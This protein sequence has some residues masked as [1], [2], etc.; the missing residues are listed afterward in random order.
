MIMMEKTVA[1]PLGVDRGDYLVDLVCKELDTYQT[2]KV[3]V[4]G[5]YDGYVNVTDEFGS[6][7][8]F[9]LSCWRGSLNPRR[10]ANPDTP[11]AISETARQE[12]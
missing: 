3:S 4:L 6:L 10:V 7:L 9:T 8:Q 11:T 12:Y 5:T 1:R 2:R